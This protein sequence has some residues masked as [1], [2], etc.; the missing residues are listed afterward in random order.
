M[1]LLERI[2]K[3]LVGAMKSKDEARLSAIRMI[4]TA[5]KKVEIDSMKPLDEAAEMAVLNSLIKQR[6]ESEEMIR[7]GGRIGLAEKEEVVR[8]LIGSYMPA[9][10]TPE[11]YAPAIPRARTDTCVTDT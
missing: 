4:K 6:T 7:K 9:P 8:K 11:E 3:D 2:Q 10:D 5:L 1:P